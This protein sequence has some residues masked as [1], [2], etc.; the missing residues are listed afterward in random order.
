MEDFCSVLELPSSGKYDSTI[1][2]VARALRPL[3]TDPDLDRETLFLRALFAWLIAD[4]DLHLKNLALLKTAQAGDERFTSV[5]LA[6]VYDAVTTRVFPGF[7]QDRMALRLAGK[8]DRL[9]PA[10]FLTLAR[11]MELPAARAN[12]LM[13]DCARRLVDAA[14]LLALPPPFV[15][16]GERALDR[17]R[18]LL[19]MRSEPFL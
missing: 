19:Q 1:E 11:T 15:A 7:G 5:R 13:A 9:D 4:G 2:R 14:P 10:D 3:S 12:I 16:G 17:I 8:D 18:A 6:P